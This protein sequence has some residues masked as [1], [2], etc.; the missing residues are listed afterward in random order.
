MARRSPTGLET[1]ECEELRIFCTVVSLNI[2]T[3]RHRK[4]ATVKESYFSKEIVEQTSEAESI[5]EEADE[6]VEVSSIMEHYLTTLR[7]TSK[8]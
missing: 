3:S 7:K 6:E 1:S 2:A 5:V 8:K 4:V